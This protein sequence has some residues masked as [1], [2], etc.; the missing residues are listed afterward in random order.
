MVRNTAKLGGTASDIIVSKVAVSRMP[1]D[2]NTWL[3][4]LTS[5]FSHTLA[6]IDV[7]DLEA[8]TCSR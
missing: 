2:A 3:L 7:D 6:W 4:S 5:P 8:Y 1:S